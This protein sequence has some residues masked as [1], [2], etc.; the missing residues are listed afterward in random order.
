MIY[1]NYLMCVDENPYMA[2]YL[3]R[4][5][6]AEFMKEVEETFKDEDVR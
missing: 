4:N 3:M 5:R 1:Y 6:H 2:K